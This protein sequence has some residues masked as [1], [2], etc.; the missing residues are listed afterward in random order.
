MY[1]KGLRE[2]MMSK[3]GNDAGKGKDANKGLMS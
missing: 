1:N 3:R 2:G